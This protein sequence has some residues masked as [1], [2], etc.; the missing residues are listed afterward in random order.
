M[1]TEKN[2][3]KCKKGLNKTQIGLIGVSFL[4]LGTSIYGI[5]ELT[6]KL[7]SIFF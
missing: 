4:I 1:E 5:I 6:K 2:C 7:I 3:S